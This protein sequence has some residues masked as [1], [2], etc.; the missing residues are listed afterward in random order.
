[1][2]TYTDILE[3]FIENSTALDLSKGQSV[4]SIIEEGIEGEAGTSKVIARRSKGIASTLDGYFT[5]PL[6]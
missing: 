4:Y 3:G 5:E 2:P 1:M 6:G